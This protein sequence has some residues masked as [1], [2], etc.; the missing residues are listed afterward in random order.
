ME[1]CRR[2]SPLRP[3]SGLLIAPFIPSSPKPRSREEKRERERE[4]ERERALPLELP[5]P[6]PTPALPS[7]PAPNTHKMGCGSSKKRG[8]AQAAGSGAARGGGG[9]VNDTLSPSQIEARI[10]SIPRTRAVQLGGVRIRYAH[11]TQRGYY[12]DGKSGGCGCGCGGG[13]GLGLLDGAR[14]LG[15]A[16]RRLSGPRARVL[17]DAICTFGVAHQAPQI[18]ICALSLPPPTLRT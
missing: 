6:S 10:E 18:K 9:G 14:L 5:P 1:L 7:P 2:L 13:H 17:A 12:P 16:I 15:R 8:G 3:P 4:R 11:L